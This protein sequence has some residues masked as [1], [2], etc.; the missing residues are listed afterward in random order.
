[1][2]VRFVAR[3]WAILTT[4]LVTLKMMIADRVTTMATKA[5]PISAVYTAAFLRSHFA[6]DLYGVFD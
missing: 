4:A 3:T 6:Q 1:L 5:P 2:L